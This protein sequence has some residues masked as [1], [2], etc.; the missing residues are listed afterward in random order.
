M[1][2]TPAK[3]DQFKRVKF[4]NQI[5]IE[6]FS[7]VLDADGVDVALIAPTLEALD[8]VWQRFHVRPVDRELAQRVLIFQSPEGK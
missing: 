3:T 6:G 7:A 5:A 4:Q 8:E 2:S 1:P